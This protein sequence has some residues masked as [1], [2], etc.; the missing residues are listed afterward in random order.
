MLARNCKADVIVIAIEHGDKR[1][2]SEYAPYHSRMGKGEGEEYVAFLTDTLKPY[3][4]KHFR[5]LPDRPHTGIGGSS[6]GGLIS[7]FGGLHRPDVFGK[8]MIFSPSLWVSSQIYDAAKQYHPP[9]DSHVYLFAGRKESRYMVPAVEGMRDCLRKWQVHVQLHIDPQGK[10][11]EER[12][13]H[14]FPRALEW[15]FFEN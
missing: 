1:R 3:V 10:H 5:T 9:A 8:L 7:L 15:L 6:M 2:L 13:G 12:W 14:E 11:H 4:D